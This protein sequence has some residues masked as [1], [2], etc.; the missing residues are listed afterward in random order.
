[1]NINVNNI[2]PT[3]A[4]IEIRG[5]IGIPSAWQ[6]EEQRDENTASTYEKFQAILATIVEQGVTKLRLN[7]R[8]T[9]GAVQDALLIHGALSELVGV[10]IETHCY[11]FVASSATIIAQAA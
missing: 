8:S 5:E 7:I 2:S 3:Q 11:G 9:G 4:T 10:E 1:M 6:D